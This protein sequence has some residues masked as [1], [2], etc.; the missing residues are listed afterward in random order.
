[1]NTCK[2][3]KWHDQFSGVC[4]NGDSEYRT[5]FTDDDFSC[6]CY[7]K[8]P[9]THYTQIETSE[10]ARECAEYC[11]QKLREES[12][13]FW[14]SMQGSRAACP[15]CKGEC[16]KVGN[17]YICGFCMQGWEALNSESAC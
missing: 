12:E 7:E 11:A 17:T 1:M 14:K 6:E 2:R 8:K 10:D 13:A 9:I 3:C 16:L 15:I 4:C 5:D